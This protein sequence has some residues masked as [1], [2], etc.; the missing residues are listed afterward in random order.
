M[1]H[2]EFEII[3]IIKDIRLIHPSK[4]EI[5]TVEFFKKEVNTKL[6]DHFMVHLLKPNQPVLV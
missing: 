2:D 4:T 3:K 5:E 6:N 1:L